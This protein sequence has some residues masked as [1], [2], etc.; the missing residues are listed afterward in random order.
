MSDDVHPN[1]SWVPKP[2]LDTSKI[3]YIG[4]RDLDDGEKKILRDLNIK[5]FSMFEVD[6]FGISKHLW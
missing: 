1:F 4:L 5:A 3:V 2:R 6:K